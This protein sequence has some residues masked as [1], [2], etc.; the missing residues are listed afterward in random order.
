MIRNWIE[1]KRVQSNLDSLFLRTLQAS[2][3]GT[4]LRLSSPSIPSGDYLFLSHT[5][6]SSLRLYTHLPCRTPHNAHN[7]HNALS[8]VTTPHSCGYPLRT[9]SVSSPIASAPSP[10][11]HFSME[12]A[13]ILRFFLNSFSLTL[14]YTEKLSGR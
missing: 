3:S 11:G 1:E 14:Y 12:V 6:P 10:S 13:A 5:L 9:G 7:A 4:A 2:V 8:L